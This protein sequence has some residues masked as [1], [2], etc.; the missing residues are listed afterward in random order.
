MDARFDFPMRRQWMTPHEKQPGPPDPTLALWF[1]L[2]LL[3]A[4]FPATGAGVLAWLSGQ[5]VAAAVLTG[6]M[7]FGGTVTLVV[8][9]IGLLRQRQ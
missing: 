2:G 8:L 5:S 4:L 3:F 1:A 7:T 6:V 9:V